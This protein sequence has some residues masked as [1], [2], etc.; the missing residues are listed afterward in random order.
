MRQWS[1]LSLTMWI[2]KN[3]IPGAAAIFLPAAGKP[4]EALRNA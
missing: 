1:I 3:G 4:A 2:L